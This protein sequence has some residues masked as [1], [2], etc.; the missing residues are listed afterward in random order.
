MLQCSP[1]RNTRLLH[2]AHSV[3]QLLAPSLQLLLDL[4]LVLAHPL[5]ELLLES[6]QLDAHLLG[7][8]VSTP[9]E[10]GIQVGDLCLLE[11]PLVGHGVQELVRQGA[12]I[13]VLDEVVKCFL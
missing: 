3:L 1:P 2:V 13:G 6:L 9:F 4:L 11:R 5:L 12:E 7:E 8:L 10:E